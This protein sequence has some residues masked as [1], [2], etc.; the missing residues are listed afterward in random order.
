MAQRKASP[1]LIL[2]TMILEFD[3]TNS[4][5]Q[6]LARD[7]DAAY[8]KWL[9]GLSYRNRYGLDE[10]QAHN[11]AKALKENRDLHRNVNDALGVD[12]DELTALR[13]LQ[14]AWCVFTFAG[15]KPILLNVIATIPSN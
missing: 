6:F 14:N 12:D 10:K 13:G 4:V 5:S 8:Q 1:T 2:F 11:V 15:R 7:A 9:R 3:G